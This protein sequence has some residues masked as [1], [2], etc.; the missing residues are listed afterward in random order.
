MK[1]PLYNQI[2][3][4]WDKLGFSKYYQIIF[5]NVCVQLSPTYREGYFNNEINHLNAISNLLSE[6]NSNIEKRKNIINLLKQYTN[7]NFEGNDNFNE[8]IQNVITLLNEL[9]KISILIVGNYGKLRELIGYD[10]Y[11]NKFENDKINDYNKD[12]LIEL[13]NDTDFFHSTN[14]SNYFSFAN[15]NDPFLTAIANPYSDSDQYISIPIDED[16]LEKIKNCQY[17]LLNEILNNEF[18][19]NNTNYRNLTCPT[20]NS[21][22]SLISIKS[23]NKLFKN[24]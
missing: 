17:I 13:K 1:D 11:I 14:L 9:R 16:S 22:H 10:L 4:L 19:K 21:S 8:L 6:I 12:Y 15:E 2:K 3:K 20:N 5:D 23:T 7:I 24:V 18:I